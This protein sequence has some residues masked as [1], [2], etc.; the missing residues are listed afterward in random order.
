[1]EERETLEAKIYKALDN[2]ETVIQ[3]NES[4]IQTW[5]PLEYEL[6]LTYGNDKVAFSE[7]L[8]ELRA[9]VRENSIEKINREKD[10]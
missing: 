5:I 1:M 9:L 7:Y 3:H 2:L 4:Y 6:Q 8:T 10:N